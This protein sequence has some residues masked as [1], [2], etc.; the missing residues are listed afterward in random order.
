MMAKIF[1][2]LRVTH[3]L[4]DKN[5]VLKQSAILYRMNLLH[6]L[7]NGFIFH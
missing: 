5:K 7:E 1:I 2:S 4:L 3:F 6:F